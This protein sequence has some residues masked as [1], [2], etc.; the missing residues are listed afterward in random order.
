MDWGGGVGGSRGEK[1]SA[2]SRTGCSIRWAVGTMMGTT[3]VPRAAL[4]VLAHG[5][6]REHS[7]AGQWGQPCPA[8]V[9]H[10]AAAEWAD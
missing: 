1:G 2:T 9:V 10:A 3:L 5:A 7:E 4:V 6:T 8:G